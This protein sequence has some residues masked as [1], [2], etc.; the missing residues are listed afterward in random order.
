MKKRVMLQWL[1]QGSIAIPKLLMT[2]YQK[3]GLNEAEFMVVLHVHT[4][5]ES[6]NLFPTP[7]EIAAR[8]T[9]NPMQCADIL[10]VLLQ[11][12][13]LTIE[14]RRDG[15]LIC[16]MY[17]L[18]PLWEKMLQLLMNETLGEEVEEERAQQS[19]LYSIFEQEFGRPLSPF[20]CETL[21]MWQ[22][23]DG[24]DG[25]VIQAALREAVISG[26]LNFR[27]IDRILFEWKKNGVKTVE[28][29]HNYGKK[30]RQ[31]QKQPRSDTTYTGKVP[32][33]NWLEQ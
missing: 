26:K 8:M 31:H 17:S 3:L 21:A 9:I 5:L 2:N 18:Q 4:F 25:T 24:H 1:E 13:L 28:Q 16:E 14:G 20:E 23:Q 32:F 27:Y 33:Y 7:N 29:A 30:F 15:D 22:D 19:S 12:G 11:R 6:G 10:R